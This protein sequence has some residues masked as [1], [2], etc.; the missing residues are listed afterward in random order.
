[1]INPIWR[2]RLAIGDVLIPLRRRDPIVA[3]I[4]AALTL[5]RLARDGARDAM[6][7][8]KEPRALSAQ[9]PGFGRLTA[10]ASAAPAA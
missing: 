10:A 3:L 6:Q 4:H 5:R 2:G 9:L 8:I 1:M 7:L